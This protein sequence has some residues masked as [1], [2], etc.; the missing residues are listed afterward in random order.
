MLVST[1]TAQK[2]ASGAICHTGVQYFGKGGAFS[3][4]RGTPVDNDTPARKGHH[5]ALATGQKRWR[6]EVAARN[7]NAFQC[8]PL[9]EPRATVLPA[10]P[11]V[12]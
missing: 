11:G 10:R 9:K 6:A 4:E 12:V 8:G 5:S 1:Q 3:Y 2:S 7:S